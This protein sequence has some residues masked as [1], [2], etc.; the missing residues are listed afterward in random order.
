ML[1]ER[2]VH[3][4]IPTADLERARAFYE[5]VLGF[6]PQQVTPAAVVYGA[7]SGSVFAATTSSGRASGSHTQ[8]GF[9][10]PDLAAD[11]AMLQAHGVVFEEYD[12]PT[13]RTVNGIAQMPGSHAAWFKDPEGNLI[14]IVQFDEAG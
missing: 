10:S 8:M 5:A 11:V 6:V 7:G 12:F 9:T 2:R 14:G 3:A 13:L 1:S 4:T